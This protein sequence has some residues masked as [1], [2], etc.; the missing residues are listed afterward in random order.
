MSTLGP[1]ARGASNVES[2][3]SPGLEKISQIEDCRRRAHGVF[4]GRRLDDLIA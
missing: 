3:E 4:R 2:G 1:S